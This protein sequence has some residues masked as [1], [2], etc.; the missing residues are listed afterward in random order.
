MEHLELNEE[1]SLTASSKKWLHDSH[2]VPD[3][4]TRISPEQCVI[5]WPIIGVWHSCREQGK[6]QN[7]GLVTDTLFFSPPLASALCSSHS[8]RSSHASCKMPCSPCLAY[9][10]LVMQR[11]CSLMFP[12]LQSMSLEKLLCSFKFYYSFKLQTSYHIYF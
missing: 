8:S 3:K 6:S 4:H 9:K 1:L 5:S 2:F 10:T 12:S 11:L 7:N